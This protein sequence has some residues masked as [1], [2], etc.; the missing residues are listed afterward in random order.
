MA[1]NCIEV[2]FATER[3][4]ISVSFVTKKLNLEA[5]FTGTPELRQLYRGAYTVTP[6]EETQTLETQGLLMSTNV[7]INP[8]PQNYGLITQIGSMIRIS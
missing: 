3:E 6:T 8:I 5:D 2:E 4:P 1:A 7:V